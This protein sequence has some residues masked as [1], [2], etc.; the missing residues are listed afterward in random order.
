FGLIQPFADMIKMLI[1]EDI[2]PAGADYW[3]HLFAAVLVPFPGLLAFAV[4]PFGK[5]MQGVDLN[6]G[7]LYIIALSG[8]TTVSMLMAGWGSRNKYAVLGGFRTAAQ[9]VG[10]EVPLVLAAI[11]AIMLSGSMAL[12][13][14]VE[15]QSWGTHS[16]AWW[17][18]SFL[19][20]LACFV[21]FFISG[22]AMAKRAPFD[23]PE[24]DSEIVAGF[25]IEYSGLKFGMFFLSEYFGLMTVATLATTLFLGGWQ[26]PFVDTIPILSVFYFLFKV[27]ALFFVFMWFRATLPRLRIDQLM[28]FSWKRLLPIALALI[29]VTGVGIVVLQE[30]G[31]A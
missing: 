11:P 14:I 13:V 5:G 25:Y 1:K 16:P 30:M 12:N 26:G 23:I 10:Y 17:T 31:W 8:F 2:V 20:R 6:I 22:V 18:F 19:I 15:D 3:A 28:A 4:I 29:L 24:A 27:Y 21:V 9:M 7:V